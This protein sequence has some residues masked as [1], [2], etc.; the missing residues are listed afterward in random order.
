MFLSS[1]R[2]PRVGQ[3]L[4]VEIRQSRRPGSGCIKPQAKGDVG[5]T[6]VAA[7][8]LAHCRGGPRCVTRDAVGSTTHRSMAMLLWA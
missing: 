8:E 7:V 6:R 5:S 2:R 3:W 1:A 4:G